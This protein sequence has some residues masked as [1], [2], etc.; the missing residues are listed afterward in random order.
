M[1]LTE[2]NGHLQLIDFRSKIWLPHLIAKNT[3]LFACSLC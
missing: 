1:K 2:S 3:K